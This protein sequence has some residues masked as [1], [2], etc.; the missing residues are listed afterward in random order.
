MIVQKFYSG[1][2][3]DSRIEKSKI[4]DQLI[5]LTQ[6]DIK[7]LIKLFRGTKEQIKLKPQGHPKALVLLRLIINS[8]VNFH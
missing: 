6:M 7:H 1:N 8:K 3:N 4:L 5:N 2:K